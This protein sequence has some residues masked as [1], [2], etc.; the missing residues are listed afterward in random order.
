MFSSI[1][2]ARGRAMPLRIPDGL[3]VVHKQSNFGWIM[4]R[5]AIKTQTTQ[6]IDAAAD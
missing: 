1:R 3:Y 6:C 4:G 2:V 5:A